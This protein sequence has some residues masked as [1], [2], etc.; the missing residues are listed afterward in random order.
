M[1]HS[2]KIAICDDTPEM[3]EF[4]EKDLC[5]IAFEKNIDM[6]IEQ[7]QSGKT[8]LLTAHTFDLLFLDVEMPEMD[9]FELAEKM[10]AKYQTEVVFVTSHQEWIQQ[11]FEYRPF[12]YLYKP[13]KKQ[14]LRQV[15]T[16]Y[17]RELEKETSGKILVKTSTGTTSIFLAEIVTIEA[18][19]EETKINTLNGTYFSR[20]TLKNWQEKLERERTFYLCN[21]SCIV[22]FQFVK[23]VQVKEIIMQDSSLSPIVIPCRKRKQVKEAY[24]KYVLEGGH[25]LYPC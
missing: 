5:L 2:L 1:Q 18:A 4:I 17:L 12:A 10:K 16:R 20:E 14:E 22:N 13:V 24:R 9:G 6:K 8:L 11:S 3:L 19:D 23:E 15:L 25:G 7:F 21:R